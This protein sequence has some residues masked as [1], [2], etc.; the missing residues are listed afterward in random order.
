MATTAGFGPE[1]DRSGWETF[2]G[3]AAAILKEY[4]S[5]PFVHYE[6]TKLG[7]RSLLDDEEIESVFACTLPH[8]HFEIASYTFQCGKNVLIEKPPCGTYEEL[9]S[10]QAI[11]AQ[12]GCVLDVTFDNAAREDNAWLVETV[13][14]RRLS[15]LLGALAYDRKV[16]TS[17]SAI[18]SALRSRRSAI[19][20]KFHSVR[21]TTS[22]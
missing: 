8:M 11:S 3:S 7:L 4:G 5:I 21:P 17:A 22:V 16:E 10:L 18:L 12:S 2:L 9:A 19:R 15:W 20:S 13:Q 6:R 14:Q 1:G